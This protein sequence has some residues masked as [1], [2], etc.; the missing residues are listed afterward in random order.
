MSVYE[1][2]LVAAVHGGRSSIRASREWA[3]HVTELTGLGRRLS[4]R[5]GD[6][7]LLDLK[8]LELAKALACRPKLLLLDEIAG[9]LTDLEC[10]QLLDIVRDARQSG[11]TIVWIEH[12]IHALRRIASRIAVLY[13]GGIIASDAPAAVLADPRVRQVYLGMGD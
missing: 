12:V 13:G 9:G 1:N 11:A 8:R 4:H 7:S 2:V 6:L 3:R 5:A 10:D